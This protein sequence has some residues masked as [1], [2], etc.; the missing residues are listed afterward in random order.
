[1]STT[2]VLLIIIA[3][4]LFIIAATVTSSM[5]RS[6][7]VPL[8]ASGLDDAIK[9]F[10]QAVQHHVEVNAVLALTEQ[11]QSDPN[12]LP[13]LSEYSR[14]AVS[15]ALLYRVDQIGHD[16]VAVQEE[17]S[18]ARMSLARNVE[19]TTSDYYRG[20][21]DGIEALLAHLR[22]ELAEAN[23]AVQE[24]YSDPAAP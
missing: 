10:G 7:V 23:A 13:K 19:A 22:A 8:I 1:M 4:L 21:V 3:G 2:D 9:R 16:I 12:L 24:F 18:R 5:R 11:F 6:P 14:Q 15:A 17:L 20:R